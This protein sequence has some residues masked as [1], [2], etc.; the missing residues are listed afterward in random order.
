MTIK[1]GVGIS[2]NISG[3]EAVKEAIKKSLEKLGSKD[4]K[5]TIILTSINYENELKNILAYL[6]RKN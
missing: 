5:F 6:Q 3:V 4:P 2:D 1:A